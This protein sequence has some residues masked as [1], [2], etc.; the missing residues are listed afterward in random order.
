MTWTT[1]PNGD[2]QILLTA[3]NSLTLPADWNPAANK[4]ECYANGCSS[5]GQAGSPG[6]G[7]NASGIG[8]G[9]GGA[10]TG[11]QKMAAGGGGAY[12]SEINVGTANQVV[13]FHVGQPSCSD[14]WFISATTVKAAGSTGWKGG[15]TANSV[16]SVLHRG[17]NGPTISMFMAGA[18]NGGGGAGPDGQGG[19]ATAS[20]PGASGGGLAGS[21]GLANGGASGL[22]AP[23][24]IVVTYTPLV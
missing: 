19:D 24:A 7:G 23:G 17:G 20:A 18:L 16:G 14:T 5:V 4:V 11:T 6:I 9:G 15:T 8:G 10:D 22:A 21:G 2:K 12:A 13:G 3:G 1:L